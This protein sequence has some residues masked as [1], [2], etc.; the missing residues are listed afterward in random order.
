MEYRKGKGGVMAKIKFCKLTNGYVGADYV[1]E[2][3]TMCDK[4]DNK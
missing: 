3:C 2:G 4:E 1:C